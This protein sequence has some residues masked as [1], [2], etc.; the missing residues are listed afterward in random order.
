ML[1]WLLEAPDFIAYHMAGHVGIDLLSNHVTL[2]ASI[3]LISYADV[4]SEGIPIT[5]RAS[6]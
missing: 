3:Q 5:R 4:K 1:Q 6:P 2:Q